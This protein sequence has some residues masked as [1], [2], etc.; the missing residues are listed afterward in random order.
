MK[1]TP[2][3]KLIGALNVLDSGASKASPRIMHIGMGLVCG[4]KIKD[5]VEAG[6]EFTIYLADWHAWINNKL[7]GKME[8]IRASG[9]YFKECF[10]GLGLS[11]VN[12]VWASEL[13][14]DI[15]YWEKVVR[16]AK[17]LS[18]NRVWRAL[19]IMG[20]SMD[21]KDLES[22]AIFYPCMQAA[23]IFYMDVDVACAGM[24]QRKVHMLARDVAEKLKWKKPVCLHTH[25]LVGLSGPVEKLEG[26]YDENPEVNFQI[27][28][29]MSKSIPRDSI[30]VHDSPEEIREK[31]RMAFC[32]P[33]ETKLN[34]VLEIAKYAIFPAVKSF[35]LIRPMKYG[36]ETVY[37][38]YEELEEDYAKGLV[39]PLDLKVS[40][41]EA[42][43]KLLEGV[44]RRFKENP[45]PLKAVLGLR[46]TR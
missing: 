18:I 31:V 39:H 4:N 42:L 19:P 44:R 45:N 3:Q 36:G 25:L 35:K 5:M 27:K 29:K 6:F 40:V 9:E 23:D 14:K 11:R 43:I 22:A 33:K 41:S 13:A 2:P 21:A 7:E 32:P 20:R 37:E 24:D 28:A 12:Y 17:R 46:I 34:P 15:E 30:F 8:N 26:V 1:P 38:S 16:I 10:A